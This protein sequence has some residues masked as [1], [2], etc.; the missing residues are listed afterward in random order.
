MKSYRKYAI[1]KLSTLFFLILSLNGCAGFWPFGKQNG[2]VKVSGTQFTQNDEP[3]YFTGTNLWYACYLGSPG[4]HGDRNRLLRELDS[5]Q[6]IGITNI[7][8]LAGSE[9][10]AMKRTLKPSMTLAPAVFDDSLL[11]GLDFTIAEMGKR[12]M[13]VVL[14]LTNYWEW[15]GGMAQY[16]V[17]ADS[18]PAFNPDV[19]GWDAFMNFSAS[20]YKNE[21]ANLFFR[22]YVRKLLTRINTANG[23]K[24]CNDPA[25][26]A[27]QLAN[28]PRPGTI[29]EEGFKNVPQYIRWV[30]ETA[31]FIKSLDTNHLVSTGSEGIIGSLRS[32]QYYRT[33][34]MSKNIDYMTLHLWPSIWK[35]F[36]PKDPQG[37]FSAAIDSSLEYIS[38]HIS[39]ARKAG[40]P[41]VLEEFGIVRD[42]SEY[43]ENI[44]T[45]VRDR[46]FQQILSFT[47]DSARAGSPLAGTNFWAWGGEGRSINEDYMWHEGDPFTGDPPHEPQGMHSVFARDSSTS[48]IIRQYAKK[49]NRLGKIDTLFARSS[50]GTK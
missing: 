47:Y 38:A 26:M 19:D 5:L 8:L 46:F 16:I 48:A 37:T 36:D 9:M 15:S 39:S 25:I 24:Y 22:S 41:L 31:G 33:A 14:F 34:H 18:V 49:M 32:E 27:W 40:K 6:S 29:S 45:T 13:K 42:N 3:Y 4:I 1:I 10:S 12:D 23:K 7:R 30:D 21:K 50:Y 28:E 2:F 43:A 44:P 20:F 35:W 11:L 17:W